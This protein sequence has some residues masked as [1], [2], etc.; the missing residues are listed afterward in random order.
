MLLLRTENVEVEAVYH[1]TTC[2]YS[3]ILLFAKRDQLMH[4]IAIYNQ[5]DTTVYKWCGAGGKPTVRYNA[6]LRDFISSLIQCS[7]SYFSE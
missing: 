6:D 5:I 3:K 1:S 4:P 7:C 2:F